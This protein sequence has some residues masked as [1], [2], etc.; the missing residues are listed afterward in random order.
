MLL[1]DLVLGLRRARRATRP[2]TPRASRPGVRPFS[3]SARSAAN[4]GL[5]PSMMSVPRPA[6]LVATVTAPLRPALAMIAASRACCLALRTSCGMPLRSSSDGQPLG[7]RDAGRA[8]EH[9]LAGLVPL[10]DV[11]DDGGELRVLALVDE[12]GLVAADHRL[13]RRDRHDAEL[14]G[15]VQLVGL[16]L[17]RAGH[18]GQ[19]LV[20]PEVVLQRDRGQRLVLLLDLHALLGLDGLVHALVVAPALQHAAGELVD[21]HHVAVVDDVVAVALEQLLGLQRVVQV[22]DERGVRGLVEV[23]DAELVLDEGHALLGDRDGALALFDLVVL[24]LLHPRRRCA[25]TRGTSAGSPRP[26]R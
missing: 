13:V 21:D 26:A 16:G 3:R 22:A 12:V 9:R 4:S 2:R 20:E 14:V 1:L 7:L 25:R 11:V 18:P 23:V 24:V 15:L 10:G 6:M 5:P 17:G 19:L 8:D